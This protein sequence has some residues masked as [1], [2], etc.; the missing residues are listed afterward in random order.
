[1]QDQRRSGAGTYEVYFVPPNN[2]QQQHQMHTIKQSSQQHNQ[3]PRTIQRGVT[4]PSTEISPDSRVSPEA[5]TRCN[6]NTC[7]FWPHCSQRESQTLYSP[8]KSGGFSG[9]MKMSQSYPAHNRLTLDTGQLHGGR[10]SASSSPA[11]LEQMDDVVKNRDK[12]QRGREETKHQ[13]SKSGMKPSRRSPQG[14]NGSQLKSAGSSFE[15]VI[16]LSPNGGPADS[17]T[18][19]SSSDIWVTTSDRTVTK[20]PRNAK[21]SGAS[22]PME[23]AM[24]GSFV[25]LTEPIRDNIISRPGS[26]P[27]QR[28]DC[29]NDDTSALDPHQRSLS[30]PKSFLTHN[31]IER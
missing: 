2:Q 27:A 19:S 6:S 10:N 1:M 7:S 24:I 12:R 13:A 26:A 28:E 30:L 23:D 8:V 9:S 17:S 20:S 21:S 25:T 18:S 31:A 14:S 4:T 15:G 5:Q 3:R 22:T 11:S 29:T 16:K